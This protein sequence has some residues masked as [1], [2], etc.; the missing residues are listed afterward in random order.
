MTPVIRAI[1]L[2][3][4]ACSAP[5]QQVETAA[6][7]EAASIKP[8]ASGDAN[9]LIRPSG[10]RLSVTNMTL[11]D[12]LTFAYRVRDFQISG[13]PGWLDSAHYDIEAKSETNISNDQMRVMLQ[14]LLHDRF[15][16]MLHHDTK[17]LPIYALTV[18]KSE[19]K[20]QP[21]KEGDCITFDPNNPAPLTGRKPSDYCGNLGIGRGS[22]DATNASMAELATAFSYILG[23]A[24]VDKT[25]LTGGF[26]IH[27]KFAFDDVPSEP[28]IPA[29]PAEVTRPSIFTVVQ[30]QLGLKLESAKGPVDI[31]VIDSVEKPSGN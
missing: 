23:R 6:S 18:A 3:A 16:L 19:L 8:N 2:A 11:K 14:A 29:P 21:L 22:L 15:K 30:E 9:R 17:E 27:L 10:G 7:F 25:G 5:G 20:V 24:V 28:G 1:L 12:L 26:P 4:A 13:G 31:L